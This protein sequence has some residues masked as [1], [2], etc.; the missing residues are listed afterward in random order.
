[1]KLHV[2]IGLEVL[3]PVAAVAVDGQVA[4]SVQ[5]GPARITRFSNDI[6]ALSRWN[7]RGLGAHVPEG[8]PRRYR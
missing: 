6:H 5:E 7:T 8:H 3:P 1:M 2:D 4:V